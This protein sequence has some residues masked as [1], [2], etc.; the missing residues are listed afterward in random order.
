MKRR[1]LLAAA[2]SLVALASRPLQAQAAQPIVLELFTSQSCS[3]CPPADALLTELARDRPDLLPLSFHV[4]YWNRLGWRDRFSLQAAT[5]RQQGYARTLPETAFGPG[6][7]YTPQLVVH[8]RRDAVGS[9][10]A[11]VLAAIAAVAGRRTQVVAGLAV[12]DGAVEVS[13]GSGVDTGNLWLI[14]FDRRHVTQIGAGE[15]GG[16]TLAHSNVVRSIVLAGTWEGRSI[17]ATV[18]RPDGERLA[19]LVQTAEGVILGAALAG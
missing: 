10:R 11:A 16:R 5:E 19:L 18:P 4:T 17:R 15:N 9:D 7:I 3:S 12:R 6:Q 8:G 2:P 1:Q 14:G 13:V